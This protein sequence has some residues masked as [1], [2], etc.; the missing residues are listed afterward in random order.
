MSTAPPLRRGTTALPDG[1]RLGWGEWGPEDGAV[2]LYCP[3]AGMSARLGFGGALLDE[4]AVRLIALERPGLGRS[5]P[6]PD[7]A[8]S[9]F[10]EDVRALITAR[11]LGAPAIVGF[12]AGAP[13]ALACAAAGLVSAVAVVSGTDE[14]A[15]SAPSAL[16]PE[17]RALIERVAAD[18]AGAEAYFAQLSAETLLAMVTQMSSEADR[19]VYGEPSF[20]QAFSEALAEGFAQGA[21]GYARD[22]VLTMRR[23][24]FEPSRIAAPVALWY[25]E[26]DA[27]PVHSP[28][29]GA[30]LCRRIPGAHRHLL[31]AGGALLWT[32]ARAI[33]TSLL[34]DAARDRRRG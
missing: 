17:V 11:G 29:R 13:F 8:L 2:V 6:A 21:A 32:H 24:P 9:D 23:W 20:A 12:S 7:R 16:S 5:D 33:L 1:R 31:D 27:S 26:R 19:A 30:S 14:L 18:P 28:D 4:L 22:T 10:A 3:G 25:G 34:E 15:R